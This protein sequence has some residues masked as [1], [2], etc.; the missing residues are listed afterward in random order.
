MFSSVI[1]SSPQGTKRPRRQC[2]V[3]ADFTLPQ[4]SDLDTLSVASVLL[5]MQAPWRV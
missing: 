1:I 2:A 4:Q 5:C 3:P